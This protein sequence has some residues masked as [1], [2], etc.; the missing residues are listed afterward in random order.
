MNQHLYEQYGLTI[1]KKVTGG[2]YEAFQCRNILYTIVP[3]VNMEQEEVYEYKQMSDYL[4]S[5]GDL[6]IASFVLTKENKLF[7]TVK[8]QKVV[9]LRYPYN[10]TRKSYSLGYELANFHEKG[11]TFPYRIVKNNRIG[12]WKNLWEQRVDQMELFWNDKVRQHPENYF[13]KLFVE[14]FP[15]YIGLT[16]NAIQYLVDTEIDDRPSPIDSA[17]I[18]HHR[19]N[20]TTWPRDQHV[21]TPI[22]WVLDHCSRDLAEWVR[23]LFLEQ[24]RIDYTT[25]STN[26]RDYERV[27]RLSS[28]AWRLMYSRLLFPIHYFECIEGYYLTESVEVQKQQENRL[29]S[30]LASSSEYEAF[31]SEFTKIMQHSNRSIS[32]PK[33]NW[34]IEL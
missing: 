14:S 4:I 30:Y 13:E 9:V 16:E 15:Y 19:F 5:K 31:L 32:I 25:I 18:C 1:D 28:F 34:L 23:H 26:I 24:Q 22:N 12:Q 6:S 8:E 29:S 3:V 33:V 10:Q 27:T 20:A 11:R 2:N 7:G 21:K 17:T